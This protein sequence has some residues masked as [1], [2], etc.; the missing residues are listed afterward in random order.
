MLFYEKKGKKEN[1]YYFSFLFC[2]PF[3]N[4]AKKLK[5]KVITLV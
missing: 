5:I 4:F 3:V 1:V 2:K